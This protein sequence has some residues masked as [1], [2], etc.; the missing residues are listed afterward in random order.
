V[1]LGWSRLLSLGLKRVGQGD[2]AKFEASRVLGLGAKVRLHAGRLVRPAPLAV[3][4]M[5]M[6]IRNARS[7]TSTQ[8][9]GLIT[10]ELSHRS[11]SAGIARAFKAEGG[12]RRAA[13]N[14]PSR[15]KCWHVDPQWPLCKSRYTGYPTFV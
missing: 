2:R 6:G 9:A 11:G 3:L 5:T 8:S 12:L 14:G 7:H 15:S 10:D 13:Q 4:E 1:G